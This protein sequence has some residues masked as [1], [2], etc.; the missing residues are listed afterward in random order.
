MRVTLRCP[1]ELRDLLP[2]PVPARDALPGWLRTM[3]S[4]AHAPELGG[5]VRTLKHCPPFVDALG[6]GFLLP[7]PCDL[8][9]ADGAI[10]WD[11]A[12]P[13]LALDGLSRGPISFH[14]PE[15]AQGSPLHDPERFV[16]KFVSYWTIET[17]PG[18]ATLFTHPLNR[19]ELP[20]RTLSGLVD[21]DL[22]KDG[23]IHLPAVWTDSGF[24]GVLARGTPVCQAI[25][26]RREALELVVDTLDEAGEARVR[27]VREAVAATTGVY[28][29]SFRA[30]PA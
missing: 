3:P 2:P 24:K 20:F 25:P 13:P 27:A 12:F 9:V 29:K 15:Q 8:H 4:T 1:R 7:L 30:G 16:L 18:V 26:I 22:Y 5:E 6:T 17:E 21:T 19:P 23:L 28:R 11:W 14:V 10:S